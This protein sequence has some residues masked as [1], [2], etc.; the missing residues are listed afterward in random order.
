MKKV[1]LSEPVVKY[2]L[3]E[4]EKW[5]IESVGNPLPHEYEVYDEKK[6]LKK[7]Y[8]LD[9]YAWCAVLKPGMVHFYFKNDNKAMLFKLTW[10]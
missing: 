4:V 7:F 6:R 8:S 10:G 3:A 1:T 2:E 5:L 9:E